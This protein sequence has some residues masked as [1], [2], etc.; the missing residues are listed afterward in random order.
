MPEDN[1]TYVSLGTGYFLRLTHK[2]GGA[3]VT[4]KLMS[5]LYKRTAYNVVLQEESTEKS[6]RGTIALSFGFRF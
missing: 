6:G 5:N 3:Y 4:L 1:G 2:G